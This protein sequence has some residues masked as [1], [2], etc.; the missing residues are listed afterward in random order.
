MPYKETKLPSGKYRVT[1]PTGN[2]HAKATSKKNADAQI[3]IMTQ[4]EKKK[5]GKK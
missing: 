5:G 2:V 4:A 3:R 1:G